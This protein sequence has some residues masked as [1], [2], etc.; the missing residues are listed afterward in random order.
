MAIARDAAGPAV[1]RRAV[2]R[3]AITAGALADALPAVAPAVRVALDLRPA[4]WDNSAQNIHAW[5]A[6]VLD[7]DYPAKLR[8]VPPAGRICVP[9]RESALPYWAIADTARVRANPRITSQNAIPS[10]VC[11]L[12]ASL[13]NRH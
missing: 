5:L 8:L 2:R 1:R 3:R 13:P 6:M 7:P 9:A 12:G 10:N 4:H 11:G